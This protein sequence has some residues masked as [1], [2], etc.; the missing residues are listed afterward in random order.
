MKGS[1]AARASK[2]SFLEEVSEEALK[3]YTPE[4]VTQILNQRARVSNY[5][6]RSLLDAIPKL[7]LLTRLQVLEVAR[8][9]EPVKHP[10]R[11]WL[12]ANGT[13]CQFKCCHHCRR[14]FSSRGF[15]SL[16]GIVNGDLPL[17]VTTGFGFHLQKHRPVALVKHV[18][19]LGLRPSPPPVSNSRLY[20]W[21]S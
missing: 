4:Q 19:N 20:P 15:L 8:G 2:L 5:L 9:K 6:F 12:P 17:T 18:K 3:T 14:S 16:N 11:P 13:E 7:K 1:P 21:Q 10:K